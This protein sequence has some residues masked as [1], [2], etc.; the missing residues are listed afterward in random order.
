[1]GRGVVI[2]QKLRLPLGCVDLTVKAVGGEIVVVTWTDVTLGE[3][4]EV[5][6]TID[7]LAKWEHD[8][9]IPP[10]LPTR[11]WTMDEVDE[12]IGRL[13][14]RQGQLDAERDRLV[15]EH[16]ELKSRHR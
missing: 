3:I 11:R 2:E 10:G 12:Q 7:D 9:G 13:K 8:G 1:M 15:G 4:V 16:P 6:A 5:E 14:A